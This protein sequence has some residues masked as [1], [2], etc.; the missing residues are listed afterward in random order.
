[1]TN[2]ELLKN[3]ILY[4]C[5]KYPHKDELS[6][7]R[8]TKII[9]LVDWKYAL[10]HGQKLTGIEWIFNHYGPY[11]P[12]VIECAKDCSEISVERSWN[13]YNS[14]KTVIK[15]ANTTQCP[16]LHSDITDIL[17]SMIEKSSRLY[18]DHFIQLVYS[19]YP[20]LTQP[21]Y[22]KLDLVTLAKEYQA[23]ILHKEENTE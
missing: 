4:I 22:S 13:T 8:L 18:W 19:T 17:D 7:A 10:E 12:D 6:D 11:V 1:M 9:Y 2:K 15:A 14:P 3:V 5:I 21:R 20:I 23:K 16:A